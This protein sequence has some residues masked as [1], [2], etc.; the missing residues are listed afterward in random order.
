MQ[1]VL[2]EQKLCFLPLSFVKLAKF[3]LV[4]DVVMIDSGGILSNEV[5]LLFQKR[6]DNLCN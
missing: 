1:Q 6:A 2:S 3:A 4:V 5:F